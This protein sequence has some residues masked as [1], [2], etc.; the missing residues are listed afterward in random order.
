M[1]F[2]KLINVVLPVFIIITMGYLF[3]RHTKVDSKPL[4]MACL[5][6][7]NP[8][9]YF[10]SMV[11]STLT[12][13]ELLKVFWFTV[14]LFLIFAIILKIVARI[15]HYDQKMSNAL[16]L[17]S[18]FPNSGNYG[19]PIMLFAFGEPGV[20]VGVIFMST[21]VILMNSAGVYFASSAQQ[22]MKEALLNILR[23][24]G[25]IA[26]VI[27]LLLRLFEVQLPVVLDRPITLLG[28]AAI[29][30]LLILLGMSLAKITVQRKALAFVSL[31]T[32][33]KLVAYPLVGLAILEFFF[34][35][36]SLAAK[37]MLLC[38]AT[39]TAA[40]T[41]LLAVQFDTKPELVSTVTF[42]TTAASLLTVSF[43]LSK[44]M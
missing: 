43:V 5:Y 11:K 9:L 36:D 40:T 37:I 41:T 1:L 28:N 12:T 32:F 16:M 44:L 24:P 7:F 18:G 29:P 13:A 23:I 31:A 30:T 14:I 8:A 10:N 2:I 35:L 15:M 39:P 20:T 4:A 19:L 34:P 27:G 26:V 42:T 33:M 21:Q 22:G 25:F 17:S 38:A 3:G 6:L